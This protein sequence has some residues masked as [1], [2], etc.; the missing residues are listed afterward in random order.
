LVSIA[1][2]YAVTATME[3]FV[4][5]RGERHTTDIA[6]LAGARLVTASETQ[7][8]R[9]WDEALIGRMTGG[10]PIT[11]RFMRRDNFTYIPQFTLVIVGNHAPELSTVNDA[12]RRRF[13]IIPFTFRPSLPDEN[14]T[15]RLRPEWPAILAWMIDGAR[16]WYGAGLGP[17]P[18]VVSEETEDYFDE[19]DRVQNWLHECCLLGRSFSATSEQLF[20]S[21]ENW[22]RR[23][24]EHPGKKTGLVRTL[25]RQYNCKEDRSRTAR[26]LS[27][28]SVNSEHR[29]D[30]R[31][32]DLGRNTCDA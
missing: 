1:G 17:R 19:Q 6:A 25:K 26:G 4:E 2:D 27:G 12:N 7:K 30:L 11:A 8:G 5:K 28:I 14:L 13:Q 3:A 20:A 10:D 23:N 15:D 9:R 21:F 24:G 29:A 31:D 18:C 16:E 22:C 32:G